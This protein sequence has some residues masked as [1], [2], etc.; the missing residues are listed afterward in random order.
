MP[1]GRPS[2][3]RL[4]E[5]EV[6]RLRVTVDVTGR[7]QNAAAQPDARPQ[8]VADLEST[9]SSLGQQGYLVQIQDVT[10]EVETKAA[11][12]EREAF[13]RSVFQGI[14]SP[15]VVWRHAGGGK[16]V[17]HFYNASA[18]AATVGLLREY[19]GADLDAFYAHEPEFAERVRRCF[20]TGEII[21]S[22]QE[23]TFRT[24][25]KKRYVRVTSA[26]VGHE[27]VIDSLTD[28]TELKEAQKALAENEA[29]FRRLLENAPDIIYRVALEPEP[30]YEYISP[31]A[32]AVTG[33]SPEELMT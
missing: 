8:G 9:V 11:L 5:G 25:S 20:K 27:Y 30:R 23:Y 14:P 15:T 13:F 22:E 31:A 1:C 24:T 18:N 29:R 32:T 2:C 28:L 26:R 4:A 10:Q 3:A 12:R 19:E 17:L 6:L 16:F 7:G 33:F 21:T